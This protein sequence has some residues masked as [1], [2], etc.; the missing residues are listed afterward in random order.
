MSSASFASFAMGKHKWTIEGDI[1][2]NTGEPYVTELKLSGCQEGNFTCNDGQCVSMDKRCNQLPECRDE[3]DERHC[4]I[5]MLKEGY[6]KNVPPITAQGW[7]I[8]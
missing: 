4:N 5:L 1:D 7:V 6:N 3:S 8:F 2:C